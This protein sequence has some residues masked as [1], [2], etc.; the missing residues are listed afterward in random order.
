MAAVIEVTALAKTW[1]GRTALRIPQLVLKAGSS[2]VL[3]GDNGAGK[4]TLLRIFAGLE[5][6]QVERFAFEGRLLQLDRL[7]AQV[8]RQI[9]FVHQHPY[10]FSRSALAN[11]EYGLRVR[12]TSR[13]ERARLAHEALAWAGMA[14]L[15]DAPAQRLSG[16]EQQRVALAR[17]KVLSPRVYLLDEPTA[18]LDADGRRRVIELIAQLAAADKVVVI[19]CHDL[20]MINLPGVVR[21]HLEN[22]SLQP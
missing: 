17:V 4:S 20:E 22:G 15:A 9:G 18:N 16:G 2:Y 11:V 5:P 21:L 14:E 13:N 8:R 12:G 1:G 6:A 3:S 7:P 10:M 19:A